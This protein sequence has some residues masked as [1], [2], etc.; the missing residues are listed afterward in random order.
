MAK[1][2]SPELSRLLGRIR[3]NPPMDKLN[4]DDLISLVNRAR[5]KKLTPEDLVLIEQAK[6]FKP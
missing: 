3:N 1:I 2:M 4:A 5:T 6:N